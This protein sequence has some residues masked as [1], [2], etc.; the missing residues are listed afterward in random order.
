MT[1]R[2]VIFTEPTTKKK[3]MA[4][5]FNG[6]KQWFIK[7]HGDDGANICD[8]DW[9]TIYRSYFQEVKTLADFQSAN[10]NAQRHYKSPFGYDAN[11]DI[12]DDVGESLP[13]ADH[14]IF[15]NPTKSEYCECMVANANSALLFKFTGIAT[16][17]IETDASQLHLLEIVS[18]CYEQ[19]SADERLTLLHQLNAL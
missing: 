5:E 2:R 6:D 15:L 4:P 17:E 8:M 16:T 19:F 7:L 12:L 9:G 11:L 18:E 3:Y 14:I 1:R 13:L 10:M